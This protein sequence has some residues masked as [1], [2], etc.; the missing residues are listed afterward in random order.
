M[1]ASNYRRPRPGTDALRPP[2]P[3]PNPMP[4]DQLG[5]M[6]SRIAAALGGAR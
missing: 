5:K 6:G 3:A 1:T 4:W 2:A